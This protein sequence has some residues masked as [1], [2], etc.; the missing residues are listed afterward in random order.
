M[1]RTRSEESGTPGITFL[2]GPAWFAS[3][4]LGPML[5]GL[6]TIKSKGKTDR[7]AGQWEGNWDPPT[8]FDK[9]PHSSW[10]SAGRF[11]FCLWHRGL[12]TGPCWHVLPQVC[13][14]AAW[15][16]KASFSPAICFHEEDA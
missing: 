11:L 8:A 12:G 10:F 15:P 1:E 6:H 7:E 16:T 9:H 5:L 4:L 14:Q 13:Q 3:K 2:D